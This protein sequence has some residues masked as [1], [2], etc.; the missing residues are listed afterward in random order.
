MPRV[1]NGL[2]TTLR[3]SVFLVGFYSG[4]KKRFSAS[5]QTCFDE[6]TGVSG[7]TADLLSITNILRTDFLVAKCTNLKCKNRKK[8]S[9]LKFCSKKAAHKMSV[10]LTP[11]NWSPPHQL[12]R[13]E[14]VVHDSLDLIVSR[15][16]Q[17]TLLPCHDDLTNCHNPVKF[18]YQL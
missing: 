2:K 8:N 4:L 10:K 14:E 3:L 11:D 7:E 1:L 12:F 13:L 18:F 17:Q 16:K 6:V 15:W 5:P 9:L